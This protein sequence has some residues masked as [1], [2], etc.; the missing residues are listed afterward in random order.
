M[1]QYLLREVIAD[2][3]L[4]ERRTKKMWVRIF[5]VSDD[6]HSDNRRSTVGTLLIMTIEHRHMDISWVCFLPFDNIPAAY[7]SENTLN[8]WVY[9]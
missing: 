8:K 4:F 7:I 5:D 6:W 1:T 3:S 2:F 9:I